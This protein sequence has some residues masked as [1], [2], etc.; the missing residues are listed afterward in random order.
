M[1]G[2]VVALSVFFATQTPY[3]L[4]TDNAF[5]IGRQISIVAIVAFGSTMV[6]VSGEIDLSVGALMGFVSVAVGVVLADVGSDQ[7]GTVT[8]VALGVA[9]TIGLMVGLFNG[10]VTVYG[11]IPSFIVTLGTLGV[12]RGLALSYR[13]G[14]PEPIRAGG[15]LDIFGDQDV[16]GVPVIILYM[17][18]ALL[19]AN[20]L[21]RGTLFGTQIYA[22][23][24]NAEASRMAGVPTKR[25]KI[26]V[27]AIAGTLAGFAGLLGTA[28]I[29]TGLPQLGTGIELDAI[30]AAILGGTRLSGGHGR[31]VG[32]LLGAIL[33]GV[34]NNGLTLMGVATTYQDVIKGTLIIVA[35]LFD[36]FRQ[37]RRP[38]GRSQPDTASAPGSP[39]MTGTASTPA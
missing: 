9:L 4:T 33:I 1:I 7:G 2:A 35:V 13:Q 12:L 11:Q 22:T 28:R 15:F 37:R 19:V 17:V 36:Q 32:S 34:I 16:L 25:V 31:V 10:L 18:G 30:A 27:M 5:N 14:S 29:R 23:G 24:G 20:Y 3:Y 38:H 26:T 8:L 6:I 39:A 21:M